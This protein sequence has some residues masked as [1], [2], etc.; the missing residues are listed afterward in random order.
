[1]PRK[2]PE[3]PRSSQAATQPAA[4]EPGPSTPP[5]AQRSKRTKAKPAAEPTQP[6]KGRGK[7]KGKAAKVKK[8]G[9][10]LDRDCNACQLYILPLRGEAKVTVSMG[11]C[12]SSAS[13]QYSA[14]GTE[15][16]VL[17]RSSSRL[18]LS[19]A[20]AAA[21]VRCRPDNLLDG[22]TRPPNSCQSDQG[23]SP[24]T[25]N[26]VTRPSH[27]EAKALLRLG[28][29]G[30]HVRCHGTTWTV[31]EVTPAVRAVAGAASLPQYARY[32]I[33][34]LDSPYFT[35]SCSCLTLLQAILDWDSAAYQIFNSMA[36][37]VLHTLNDGL[38]PANHVPMLH[39]L[40]MHALPAQIDEYGTA[41]CISVQHHP[42]NISPECSMGLSH[43]PFPAQSPSRDS[44]QAQDLT[45]LLSTRYCRTLAALD[46]VPSL[47]SICDMAGQV[48]EV[49]AGHDILSQ[50]QHALLY[51]GSA[52][53]RAAAS[54]AGATVPGEISTTVKVSSSYWQ[55]LLQLQ[56]E[57]LDEMLGAIVDGKPWT[58]VVKVPV[59]LV[60]S[61][62]PGSLGA[63]SLLDVKAA[64]SPLNLL[65]VASMPPGAVSWA[66]Q[67]TK[68]LEGPSAAS[69]PA[70]PEF[71]EAQPVVPHKRRG[72][73]RR[74]SSSWLAQTLTGPEPSLNG[75]SHSSYANIA[76]QGIDTHILPSSQAG[77]LLITCRVLAFTCPFVP[78]RSIQALGATYD[79]TGQCLPGIAQPA[80]HH[81]V[82]ALCPLSAATPAF[83]TETLLPVQFSSFGKTGSTSH[84]RSPYGPAPSMLPIPPTALNRA[85]SM[86]GLP[87][88]ASF[89]CGPPTRPNLTSCANT[90]PRG[91]KRST[92]FSAGSNA[93]F[94]L[95]IV[96][97]D[98]VN[99][100]LGQGTGQ[101]AS[102]LR[103]RL[104]A[105]LE[106]TDR[107]GVSSSTSG[108]EPPLAEVEPRSAFATQAAGTVQAATGTPM[109][110]KAGNGKQ[111]GD[112]QMDDTCMHEVCV[113]PFRDPET[114]TMP[115]CCYTMAAGFT[116][117]SKECKPEQVNAWCHLLSRLYSSQQRLE[118]PLLQV[119]E[120]LN[121]L[122]SYLDAMLDK[123]KVHKV[124]TA[125]DCY[126]I[127][128]GIVDEDEQGFRRVTGKLSASARTR[129][130]RRALN[131]A[132]D[133][134]QVRRIQI[135]EATYKLLQDDPQRWQATGGVEV[136]GTLSTAAERP[137]LV[138]SGDATS[139]LG[140][141]VTS[142]TELQPGLALIT[143][144]ASLS[145]GQSR[146]LTDEV[147]P[148]PSTGQ[149]WPM[150]DNGCIARELQAAQSD[151]SASSGYDSSMTLGVGA[152]FQLP[153]GSNSHRLSIG[154]A[155]SSFSELPSMH[156]LV[157]RMS[158]TSEEAS[159]RG[160]PSSSISLAPQ[161][162]MQDLVGP[163]PGHALPTPPRLHA[164]MYPQPPALPP[165]R[166]AALH[167]LPGAK[168]SLGFAG[169]PQICGPSASG[170]TAVWQEGSA[171]SGAVQFL[172]AGP[173]VRSA[174]QPH[175]G[176]LATI[177]E[178]SYR[179]SPGFASSGVSGESIAA[180]MQAHSAGEVGSSRPAQP[181]TRSGSQSAHKS[182]DHYMDLVQLGLRPSPRSSQPG[183]IMEG[184]SSF[185]QLMAQ[186][187]EYLAM[188]DGNQG[189]KQQ[190]L[191]TIV[192]G[193]AAPH[194]VVSDFSNPLFKA[195]A[196][197][198][199]WVDVLQSAL[200][201]CVVLTASLRDECVA[202]NAA[203]APPIRR[204]VAVAALS[205][206]PAEPQQLQQTRPSQSSK[207][208]ID[209][210]ENLKSTLEHQ[211][212]TYGA[213]A[214]LS[215]TFLQGVTSLSAA[216]DFTS[217]ASAVGLAYLLS[218]L[219]TGV[220]HWSVDNYG[221][222]STPL[223]GRQ[224]AAFQ[225][226]HQ[227]PWTIT[228]R[229]F[230]NNVHQVFK[231]AM[232]PAVLF[233]LASPW[234]APSFNTFM[235]TFIFL[236]CMSQQFHA[237]SHMK[238]SALPPL[239][240]ALQ[241]AGIL[242][243]RKYVH[244]SGC[245]GCMAGM[246]SHST[247]GSHFVLQATAIPESRIWCNYCIVSGLWNPLLDRSG[248]FP[249]L[250]RVVLAQTGVEP[251]SWHP[252]EHDWKELERPDRKH[253]TVNVGKSKVM[254]FNGNS[255]AQ[256][257]GPNPPPPALAQGPPAPAQGPPAPAQAPP[258][259]AQPPHPPPAQAP[260]PPAP[261]QAPPPAPAQDPPAPAQAPPPPP[262][263]QAPPA[264]APP[265]PPPAQAQPLP[266]APGP[267][268]PPQAPPGGRWL[269]RDTNGCLNLQRI[270]ESRQRPIELCRWDDL[271]ALPP[272]GKEYQQRYK[273]V[274]DRLPKGRQRL[275]RAAEYRR[276]IDGRARNNA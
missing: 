51:T 28:G 173:V 176:G 106:H 66:P 5:S 152:Q 271:E 233:L 27:Q 81:A 59:S 7:A 169:W 242:I 92:T 22:S 160:T 245:L 73:A 30:V 195:F 46:A 201:K 34:W 161:Q 177:P 132:Y 226:H 37:E 2:P 214:V 238:K 68:P 166:P 123:Y 15:A 164:M 217:M 175:A 182:A 23:N 191:S 26:L 128:G 142:S 16:A 240:V 107:I 98:G 47:F 87:T 269:D 127:C 69:A 225:G 172:H 239:V 237:W 135:S 40:S 90:V 58:H 261:A 89:P 111:A 29:S 199:R 78:M 194:P 130:A 266:A 165:L 53:I 79:Q 159:A 260:P 211:L 88:A 122:F 262:H 168:Y 55:D 50:N 170:V 38:A 144:G 134:M 192:L 147:S 183:H 189:R 181:E 114:G 157:L 202:N 253:L 13:D 126:I 129:A 249:A 103:Q 32:L 180:G 113:T 274:N 117:M 110:H 57:L 8:P 171:S 100:R 10:W 227:R 24:Q 3:A 91:L 222:G 74:G 184:R 268:L 80:R 41:S 131:F 39:A 14:V 65:R 18:I 257:R 218:D 82:K 54:Q 116:S 60:P 256:L 243:S 25:H 248:F 63:S 104:L 19:S 232:L 235:S 33:T 124:E 11:Q 155:L 188:R 223:F 231:P 49:E 252:P 125:G 118:R 185:L 255:H 67:T 12:A 42:I 112:S 138:N 276:G 44:A 215:A 264:Q 102:G 139:R 254:V 158:K 153:L 236:V 230:C 1:A 219:G 85:D 273:L 86:V 186:N 61:P 56:P 150:P 93:Q 251:R 96:S 108:P 200:R 145:N 48:W 216:G 207:W 36:N 43:Q 21:T 163:Q 205:V 20:D 162:H 228:E 174:S 190:H 75:G 210:S 141:S 9:R 213:I 83:V 197:L 72:I 212:W 220:Y 101:A 71:L 156:D 151:G 265:P 6:T 229:E 209:P 198:I 120:F 149:L 263:A 270:G 244:A 196:Y 119:M 136:K 62:L 193:P 204:S 52:A 259:P 146:H 45:G 121:E 105:L 143:P 258:P 137:Q 221:S 133:M 99:G 208:A 95:P 77:S 241:D 250:E 275:H 70:A 187:F 246:E 84:R 64:A 4:S 94:A 206:K 224:I 97:V 247:T 154:Q 148:S 31:E 267:A 115:P 167:P 178:G 140:V 234:A 203:V 272:I 179:P 109:G 35:M 76:N 17:Q